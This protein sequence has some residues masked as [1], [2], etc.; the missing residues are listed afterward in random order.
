[1]GYKFHSVRHGT[2]EY[3]PCKCAG[4]PISVEIKDVPDVCNALP[5]PL[6]SANVEGTGYQ[7]FL[8]VLDCHLKKKHE[9]EGLDIA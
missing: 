4:V 3:H 6:L 7:F 1:M 9:L 2:A 5:S 8:R